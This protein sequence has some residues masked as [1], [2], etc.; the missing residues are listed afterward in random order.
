MA[1]ADLLRRVF[2]TCGFCLDHWNK[3]SVKGPVTSHR[4]V[5]EEID[6]ELGIKKAIIQCG[7]C[8][9]KTEHFPSYKNRSRAQIKQWKAKHEAAK[10]AKREL[11]KTARKER[12][13][14]S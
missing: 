7:R 1:G 12:L 2:I 11:K 14:R 6:D 9:T 13:E 4:I 8:G 3:S 5:K 10:T